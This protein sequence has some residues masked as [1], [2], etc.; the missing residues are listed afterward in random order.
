MRIPLMVR[1]FYGREYGFE[2]DEND[3]KEEI[4]E[5]LKEHRLLHETGYGCGDIFLYPSGRPIECSLG[6]MKRKGELKEDDE[7]FA[8]QMTLGGC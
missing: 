7:L 1:T 5:R 6:E 2:F 3:G 8:A 4:I